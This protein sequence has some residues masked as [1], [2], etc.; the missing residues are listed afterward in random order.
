MKRKRLSGKDAAI[1][2][3]SHKTEVEKPKGKWGKIEKDIQENFLIFRDVDMK[4]K[5]KKIE[6]ILFLKAHLSKSNQLEC[7]P[8]L[9]F[10]FL[11]SFCGFRFD[12]FFTKSFY[13]IE[14]N[15]RKE[16][17]SNSESKAL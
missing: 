7:N 3:L 2:C 15:L 5:H 12:V 4:F 17:Q 10:I 6:F 16:N 14:S 1:P 9:N 11:N 13:I 8:R